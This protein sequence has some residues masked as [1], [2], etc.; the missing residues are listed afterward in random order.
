MQAAPAAVLTRGMQLEAAVDSLPDW[1]FQPRPQPQTQTQTPSPR[2]PPATHYSP[3]FY[4]EHYEFDADFRAYYGDAERQPQYDDLEFGR[5]AHADA[6]DRVDELSG[7]SQPEDGPPRPQ[8]ASAFRAPNPEAALLASLT[9]DLIVKQQHEAERRI[10]AQQ[11]AADAR[12]RPL[13]TSREAS[14]NS[15]EEPEATAEEED[16]DNAGEDELLAG[17]TL[18]AAAGPEPAQDALGIRSASSRRSTDSSS[19]SFADLRI[20][21]FSM[22]GREK[23]VM[24]HVDVLHSESQLQTYTIRRSYSDFKDLHAQL[25]EILDARQQYYRSRALSRQSRQDRERGGSLA[26]FSMNQEAA[27]REEALER[28]ITAFALPALPHAG[29]LSFWKRHDRAHL[30]SRC[31]SFQELLHAVLQ[32]PFLRESFAMQKFLS[33]APC[34]IR[35]R[36]SSY[37]SLCEYSVPQLDREE[38]HRERRRRAQQYRRNSSASAHASMLV[39]Y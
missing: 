33:V 27:L 9:L 22:R 23:S 25:S 14:N 17:K 28:S 20:S 29:L 2:P 10:R 38:E 39:E 31:Q 19:G 8:P 7:C 6:L 37:V 4:N 11:A 36:G 30:Q 32:Q 5:R 12:D 21:G 1:Y 24:Y 15:S 13:R 34:T 26:S 18:R 16:D 3:H 35:E